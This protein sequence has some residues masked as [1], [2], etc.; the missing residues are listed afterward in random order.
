MV[1]H[2]QTEEIKQLGGNVEQFKKNHGWREYFLTQLSQSALLC[3]K[4]ENYDKNTR[5]I[6]RVLIRRGTLS[7]WTFFGLKR[8][9]PRP[10]SLENRS[11]DV[12]EVTTSFPRNRP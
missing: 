1:T 8:R 10:L 3:L 12:G 9:S 6:G 2:R 7:R 5:I 4:N 11:P